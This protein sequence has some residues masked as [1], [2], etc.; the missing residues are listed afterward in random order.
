MSLWGQVRWNQML[1]S[2]ECLSRWVSPIV[3]STILFSKAA[4]S[5]QIHMCCRHDLLQSSKYDRNMITAD[6]KDCTNDLFLQDYV[7]T[8]HI[9]HLHAQ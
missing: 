7:Q 1:Q 5:I 9:L 3:Q 6:L 8:H 4:L 2:D